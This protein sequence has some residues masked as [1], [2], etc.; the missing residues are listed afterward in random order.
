MGC[1]K[2]KSI[3]EKDLIDKNKMGQN[4]T[5]VKE[6]ATGWSMI[7][8]KESNNNDNDNDINIPSVREELE[9]V[10]PRVDDNATDF[11]E[12]KI[13][14]TV[15][16][17]LTIDTGSKDEKEKQSSSSSPL[18]S[19]PVLSP[20]HISS[21]KKIQRSVRRKI[22]MK[23][24]DIEHQWKV[25]NDLHNCDE[26]EML[27][28][29]FF[30]QTLMDK[31]PG[32][33]K[34]DSSRLVT[35]L[36]EDD[37]QTSIK[38]QVIEVSEEIELH[39]N[40]DYT[41]FTIKNNKEI[42]EHVLAEI[43]EVYKR[44]NGALDSHLLNRILRRAY[45]ILKTNTAG[46]YLSISNKSKINI[47]G[48]LHGN[49]LDLLH[50]LDEAGLP[51]EINKFVFNGDFVDR[52]EK[53]V[54]VITLLMTLIVVYPDFVVLNRGNHEDFAVNRV[55]GF[56]NECTLKYDELTYGMFNEIFRYLPIFSVVNDTIFIV[57]G[58][59][60]HNPDVLLKDLDCI[61]RIDYCPV[62]SVPYPDNTIGLDAD[63]TRMEYLRQLQRD[64]L[65]SDPSS[66]RG[67]CKNNRGAGV[68]F[69]PDICDQFMKNNNITMIV[70]SH[71]CGI[72][73][74]SL[75]F[76]SSLSSL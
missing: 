41:N 62:P 54:E 64:A 63:A 29:A 47:I 44:P 6:E 32:A 73:V 66:N 74:S 13:E 39:G 71:E 16:P 69:G 68:Q 76:Q 59:L 8:P 31:V 1:A 55:Y 28:L 75:L 46:R 42:D 37:P 26:A 57:H 3:A 45:K 15:N 36:D 49:L 51:S 20:K 61:N 23:R 67:I 48:D 33:D 43:I 25:F 18:V 2:S 21:V 22:A 56:Q 14:K 30:M 40:K 7:V 60:F 65:W 72:I 11:N 27:H 17:L 4:N 38:L 10:S 50:I 35:N 19:S 12:K 9:K 58:G 53:S 5:I 52:G 70:R 24:C 34:W